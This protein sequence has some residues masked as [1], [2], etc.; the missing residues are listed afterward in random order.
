MRGNLTRPI[1]ACLVLSCL[2]APVLHG[3]S[4]PLPAS[5]APNEIEIRMT[6]NIGG[7]C[8]EPRCVYYR[9]TIRGDGMVR[10]E[11][12]AQPP[13][14]ER[15]RKVP[16]DETLTLMN[17]F[18]RVRFLERPERYVGHSAYVLQDGLLSLRGMDLS[19][20]ASWDLSL[21]IGSVQKSV[22]LQSGIP[23]DLG[24]LRDLVDKLGGPGAWARR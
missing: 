14:P 3:Q 15:S 2:L 24:T 21:R 10:Y 4:Q 22:H 6:R 7:G 19:T 20:G 1:C 11:D 16:V 13:V 17:E 5:I 23:D 9:V 8:P 18:L 12:L